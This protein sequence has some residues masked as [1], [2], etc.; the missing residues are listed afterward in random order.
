[1][2]GKCPFNAGMDAMKD[3]EMVTINLNQP[4]FIAEILHY[5]LTFR[6]EPSTKGILHFGDGLDILH[7]L[8]YQFEYPL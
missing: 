4:R 6:V 2:H 3:G 7:I 1:M 8:G 5:L